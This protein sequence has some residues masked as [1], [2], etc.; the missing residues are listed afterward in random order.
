MDENQWDCFMRHYENQ[1]WDYLPD[2]AREALIGL[3]WVQCSWDKEPDCLVD[4]PD[5]ETSNWRR[6]TATEKA[7]ATN[8]CW[9]RESWDE[10]QLPW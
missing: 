6:L 3:G 10:Y 1:S 8:L 7:H 2:H 5:S 9:S 4:A